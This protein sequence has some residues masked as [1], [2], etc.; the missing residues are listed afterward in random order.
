MGCKTC[1]FWSE[2]WCHIKGTCKNPKARAYEQM[3]YLDDPCCDER[4]EKKDEEQAPEV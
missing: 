1:T 2:W 3:R 4:E